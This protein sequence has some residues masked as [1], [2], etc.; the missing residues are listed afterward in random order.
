MRW[1]LVCMPPNVTGKVIQAAVSK[2]NQI[3]ITTLSAYI[4]PFKEKHFWLVG[5]TIK[6]AFAYSYIVAASV[7]VPGQMLMMECVKAWGLVAVKQ[8]VEERKWPTLI[9]PGCSLVWLVPAEHLVAS[10][11]L[12]L[13]PCDHRSP[14]SFLRGHKYFPQTP[15]CFHIILQTPPNDSERQTMHPFSHDCH[16]SL[17]LY[18]FYSGWKT[19]TYTL[20]GQQQCTPQTLH[21]KWY[22]KATCLKLLY[23][24]DVSND[25]AS[26]VWKSYVWFSPHLKSPRNENARA[27]TQ[28]KEEM[29]NKETNRNNNAVSH[30]RNK[31]NQSNSQYILV[32]DML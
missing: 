7:R 1:S 2:L 15:Y 17:W 16:A 9:Y 12:P 32:G 19:Y 5:F 29:K 3:N 20:R 14:T 18:T 30:S 21:L 11:S 26:S 25:S 13:S 6:R 31:E 23:M 24:I 10:H 27:L 4:K 8:G 22:I 28:R